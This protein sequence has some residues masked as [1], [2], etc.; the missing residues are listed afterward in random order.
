MENGENDMKITKL[1]TTYLRIPVETALVNITKSRAFMEVI[2]L[3]VETDQCITGYGYTY[4][5]GFGGRAI[6]TMLETD[7]QELVIGYDP[8]NIKAVVRRVLWELRQAGFAG[9]TVLATAALDFALWDIFSKY[10]SLPIGKLLGAYRDSIPMY[11]SIAGWIGL[12][13]EEMVARAKELIQEKGL[14]GIKIQVGRGTADQD[15]ARIKALREELGDNVKLFID[16]NTILDIPS[17]VKL[18]K[19]LTPY[20]IFWMEEPISIRDL[21][22]HAILSSQIDIPL[23]SGENFYGI[24]DSDEYI[25]RRLV[26]YLQA[27]VIRV[28][29]ITEWIRIAALADAHGIKMSPHFVMEVT[30]EVQCAIQNSL[31]VEY[32]PWF[33]SYFK[34][35]VRVENGHIYARQ[36]P[37]LGL[38]FDEDAI[39]KYRID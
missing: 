2:L 18:G 5:D 29:G 34:D 23:A 33:Q 27:D 21:E 7:I 13:R 26:A 17:A 12:P 28:G 20:D 4:T 36:S 3:K 9:I 8:T 35:P 6:Q 38:E 39:R 10:T 25:K 1:C 30:V 32:I 24:Q 15:E 22:G 31:F 37:G 19:R 14:V 11:A 16:A